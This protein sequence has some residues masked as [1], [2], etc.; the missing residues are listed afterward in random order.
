MHTITMRV[1]RKNF[2]LLKNTTTISLEPT[3]RRIQSTLL[4]FDSS[5]INKSYLRSFCSS[6]SR[7][8]ELNIL[9]IETSCDDTSA[10]IINNKGLI[11]AEHTM[12]QFHIHEPMGGIVPNLA[13]RSHTINLPNVVATTL[14]KANL[15]ITD[16]DIF[17]FTRGPG[18][19]ACLSVGTNA[20]KTLAASLRK[21]LIGVHHMEAHALTVRM[22][23]DA[24]I[25]FPYVAFLISGGHTLVII[26]YGVNQYTQLATTLDESVGEA[27]DKVARALCIPWNPVPGIEIS[28]L[29]PGR[30]GGPGPALEKVALDGDKTKYTF[31]LPLNLNQQRANIAFSFS[32]LRTQVEKKLKSFLQTSVQMKRQK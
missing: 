14:E 7:C 4:K 6:V 15:S 12:N 11:L 3:N 27:Y 13:L 10:A 21:P 1:Q 9:G 23:Q 18:I 31:T 28:E 24:N 8:R 17:A 32:G 22:G 26:V 29:V 19:P 16:I 30:G 5:L 2:N 25:T 20:T